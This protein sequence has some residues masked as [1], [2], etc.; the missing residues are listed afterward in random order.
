MV[1]LVITFLWDWLLDMEQ[2][3]CEVFKAFE[4]GIQIWVGNFFVCY[5]HFF[6]HLESIQCVLGM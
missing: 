5:G 4:Y 3:I 2:I 1:L 6:H